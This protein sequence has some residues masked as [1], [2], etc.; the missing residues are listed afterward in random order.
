MKVSFTQAEVEQIILDY[1]KTNLS[2][3]FNEIR[4]SHYYAADYCVVTCAE[5]ETTTDAPK[6]E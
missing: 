6:G 5:P 3:K 2:S 1:V 4:I